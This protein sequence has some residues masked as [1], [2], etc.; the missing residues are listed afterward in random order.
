[1]SLDVASEVELEQ[2]WFVRQQVSGNDSMFVVSSKTPKLT[3]GILEVTSYPGSP[4]FSTLH[5]KNGRAWELRAHAI[6]ERGRFL[7]QR[8][9]HVITNDV[10]GYSAYATLRTRVN[11]VHICG[12]MR[13][14][15]VHSCSHC[16]RSIIS[17]LHLL[18]GRR[19]IFLRAT[20]KNWAGPGYEAISEAHCWLF[21]L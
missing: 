3:H 19:P 5:A 6:N 20:L 12:H 15:H 14:M 2:Y 11:H 21:I 4:S 10:T 16:P 13:A 8:S 18:Y 7:A 17:V 1:M 9:A